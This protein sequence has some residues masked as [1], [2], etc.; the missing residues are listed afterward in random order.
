[1]FLIQ[2]LKKGRFT[3]D[4]DEKL[5][6][7]Y[8][9]LGSKWSTIAYYFPRRTA[10][11]IKNRFH[12]SIKKRMTFDPHSNSG[13]TTKELPLSQQAISDSTTHNSSSKSLPIIEPIQSDLPSPTKNLMLDDIKIDYST[14]TSKECDSILN[15]R[16]SYVNNE[17]PFFENNDVKIEDSLT[18]D[19]FMFNFDEFFTL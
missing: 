14:I 4:E 17:F 2:K 16:Y 3:E 18:G 13:N 6:E 8:G 10:D 19:M 12:S 11:M 15:S 7:L 5:I 9:Q 1:M